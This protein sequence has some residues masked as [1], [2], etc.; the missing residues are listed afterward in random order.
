MPRSS[1]NCVALRPP[2][3]SS[4]AHRRARLCSAAFG[5]VR[6]RYSAVFGRPPKCVERGALPCR[7]AGN[8]H[9]GCMDRNRIKLIRIFIGSPGPT[10]YLHQLHIMPDSAIDSAINLCADRNA[11]RNSIFA[12]IRVRQDN[13]RATFDRARFGMLIFRLV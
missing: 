12:P 1:T 2:R 3:V 7:L 8:F 6:L 10:N 5:L 4:R 13:A 11:S 9:E